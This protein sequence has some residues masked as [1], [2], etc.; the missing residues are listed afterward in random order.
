L[1]SKTSNNSIRLIAAALAVSIAKLAAITLIVLIAA[2][3]FKLITLI[4]LVIATPFK[5]NTYKV[6]RGRVA[7]SAT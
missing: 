4:V 7:S 3:P 1:N 6:I 2:A 5:H